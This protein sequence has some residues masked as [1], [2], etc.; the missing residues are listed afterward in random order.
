MIMDLHKFIDNTFNQMILLV[1]KICIELTHLLY[2]ISSNLKDFF[3]L[4]IRYTPKN[5]IIISFFSVELSK[6]LTFVYAN[7]NIIIFDYCE[8]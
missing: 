7:V 5:T 1:M 3:P 6:Q 8:W 2:I 4:I